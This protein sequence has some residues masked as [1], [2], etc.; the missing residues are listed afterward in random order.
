MKSNEYCRTEQAV[1][2][3]RL[4]LFNTSSGISRLHAT[5]FATVHF[6]VGVAY[7]YV[8]P[9]RYDLAHYQNK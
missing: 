5:F 8:M 1:M 6:I 4:L 9:M 2:G 3:T 7:L